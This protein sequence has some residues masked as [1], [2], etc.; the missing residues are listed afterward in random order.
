MH[1]SLSNINLQKIN[2][3][4]LNN[5]DNDLFKI[6]ILN[7]NQ[8]IKEIEHN[9]MKYNY[10]LIKISKLE[11]LINILFL[12]LSYLIFILAGFILSSIIFIFYI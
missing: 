4:D 3:N 11:Q 10:A 6:I 7:Y 9:K 12:H 2:I 5:N 8:I 1:Q